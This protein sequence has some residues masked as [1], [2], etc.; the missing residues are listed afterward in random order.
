MTPEWLCWKCGTL[1]TALVLPL[2]RHDECPKCRADLHVCRMCRFFDTRVSR[3]CSEPV[4]DEVVNKERANFCGYFDARANAFDANRAPTDHARAALD[5]LFG[6]TTA[7][8]A[9][10]EPLPSEAEQVRRTLAELFGE[11]EPGK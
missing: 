6:A 11:I 2:A 10:T 7:K 5:A 8:T 4:A 1:L 9:G 3:Q